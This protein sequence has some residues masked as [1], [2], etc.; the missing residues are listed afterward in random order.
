MSNCMRVVYKVKRNELY[1]YGVLGMKWGVRRDKYLKKHTIP[2]GTKIYRVTTDK[3]ESIQG[4]KYVTYL[5]PDRDLYRGS[6]A[7]GIR[8][9]YGKNKNAPLYENTYTLK[10]DLNI[11]S[12][13]EYKKVLNELLDKHNMKHKIEFLKVQLH[14]LSYKDAD[15][16]KLSEES[17]KYAESFIEQNKDLNVNDPRLFHQVINYGVMKDK[18]FKDEIIQELKKKG[19]N[20]MVDEASVGGK[21][22][23][24]DREG[25]DP[26]I[27][28]EGNDSLTKNETR[29]ISY[30]EQYDAIERYAKW[31]GVANKA[32]KNK[33]LTKLGMNKW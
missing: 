27:I 8:K 20:A 3:N 2:K 17:K 6:Y 19:Y 22:L 14:G 28:F 15:I 9:Q 21:E 29:N 24:F 32:E 18:T 12:R 25:V 10:E 13:K 23:G 16:S 33:L 5:P 31:Y 1:H 4:N 11:P 30:K 7:N 26:L